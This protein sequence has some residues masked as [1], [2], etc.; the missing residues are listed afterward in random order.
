MFCHRCGTQ[1][2]D[3]AVFCAGCGAAQ[4]SAQQQYSG[5][6]Q[7]IESTEHLY[8]SQDRTRQSYEPTNGSQGAMFSPEQNQRYPGDNSGSWQPEATVRGVYGYPGDKAPDKIPGAE[9]KKG[10]LWLKIAI[11]VLA[12]AIVAAG[13]YYFVFMRNPANIVA[14]ALSGISAEV[15]QRFD[16]TPFKA[17]G[18]LNDILKDGTVTVDFDYNNTYWYQEQTTGRVK[19]SSKAEEREF[20]VEGELHAY[21]YYNG[22]QEEEISVNFEGYANKERMAIGSRQFDDKYYGIRYSTFESD[23]ED[24]ASIAGLDS[25]SIDQMINIVKSIDS[26]MNPDTSAT[27]SASKKYIDELL[28]FYL[29]CDQTSEK[30]DIDSGG[31]TVRATR[32]D[33]SITKDAILDLM[34][35]IYDLLE[36]EDDI[37]GIFSNS[38]F[39]LFGTYWYTPV[40]TYGYN[41]VAPS[42]SD[43][44]TEILRSFRT[45][46]RNFE[47]YYSDTST[48]TLSF[49]ISNSDRLLRF[50]VNANL[51]VD[52][53]RYRFSASLDFGASATDKWVFR[54]TAD[55][56]TVKLVWDIKERTSS[57]ENIITI[58]YSDESITLGCVWS[59]SR[60][61]FEITYEQ[62]YG[63][64]YTAQWGLETWSLSGVYR[65]ESD[66][67]R[68]T[69]DN[70]MDSYYNETLS[71]DIVAQRGSSI[72]QIN[73]INIDKWDRNLYYRMEDFF[74]YDLNW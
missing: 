40:Y 38:L 16:T 10:K 54:V 15:S 65:E 73:Y 72:K 46:I 36:E 58:T 50:D 24:F 61:D 25:Y 60:G 29:A 63:P 4:Q 51:R 66:G 18:M 71:L 23:I 6:D 53:E 22:Y 27:E 68:L 20:A 13:V 2:P 62:D 48:I 19:L 64:Y 37:L 32:V 7:P 5:Y 3:D 12:V 57:F 39:S 1:L 43:T 70:V 44:N 14:T 34:E 67:F 28:K 52:D 49:Y 74:Y 9:K 26:F 41:A 59:P 17:Y 21:D 55:G 69:F 45:L 42:V 8:Q 47:K 35:S 33:V 30:A 11:P 31:Q 56:D